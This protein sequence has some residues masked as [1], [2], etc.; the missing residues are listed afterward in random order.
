MRETQKMLKPLRRD[1]LE[2]LTECLGHLLGRVLTNAANFV[3]DYEA[4][5]NLGID[6]STKF[7]SYCALKEITENAIEW[8][9]ENDRGR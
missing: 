5:E 1:E 4:S 7:P 2:E 9:E 8:L 6:L 3:G